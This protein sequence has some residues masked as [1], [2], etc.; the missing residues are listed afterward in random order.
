MPALTPGGKSHP[1][2][3]I[4]LVGGAGGCYGAGETSGVLPSLCIE[5]LSQ[6]K[7]YSFHVGPSVFKALGCLL[8]ESQIY[9]LQ[10]ENPVG[11]EMGKRDRSGLAV[12][13]AWEAVRD[14]SAVFSE[15]AIP[16]GLQ[17]LGNPS[18]K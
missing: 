6:G 11:E 3:R 14:S 1:F 7:Q 4:K 12:L 17:P 10:G 2:A 18:V 16:P 5:I 9:V 13:A 15:R 8:L